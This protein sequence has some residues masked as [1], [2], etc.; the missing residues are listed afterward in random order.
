MYLIISLDSGTVQS[1]DDI[2]ALEDFITDSDYLV[3]DLTRTP[4]VFFQ[5]NHMAEEPTP[6]EVPEAE[7]D[8]EE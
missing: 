8:E 4:P 2:T 1:H 5:G 7:D 3:L 6:Y